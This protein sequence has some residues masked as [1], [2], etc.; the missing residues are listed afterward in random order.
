MLAGQVDDDLPKNEEY[1]KINY[2]NKHVC[3]NVKKIPADNTASF[4]NVNSDN[5]FDADQDLLF[6]LAQQEGDTDETEAVSYTHLTLP[7]NREV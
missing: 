3:D 6:L 5:V 2:N 7:T 1:S 4:K